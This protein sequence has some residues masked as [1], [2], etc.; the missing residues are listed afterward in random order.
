MSPGSIYWMLN[1]CS[2][3]M[4]DID[5]DQQIT[6]TIPLSA[7]K[8]ILP[9]RVPA[10]I[11]S[12]KPSAH[13]NGPSKGPCLSPL[14]SEVSD[15]SSEEQITRSATEETVR[16][17]SA[18]FNDGEFRCWEHGCS[19]RNFSTRGNLVRH[20]LERSEAR[21]SYGCARCGAEFSRSSAR[22]QHV[23]SKRC[24][25]NRSMDE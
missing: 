10:S 18:T 20:C 2:L 3:D 6:M 24:A 4:M 7:L 15:I 22:N 9:S 25:R 17:R 16:T 23:A 14:P 12:K 13:F 11:G 5:D 21:R 8:G 1:F 19:G